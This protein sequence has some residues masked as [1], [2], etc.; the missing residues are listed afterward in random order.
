[1]KDQNQT[2]TPPGMGMS[3]EAPIAD[4]A[5]GKTFDHIKEEFVEEV[6]QIKEKWSL[7]LDLRDRR[8]KDLEGK[9]AQ[10]KQEE[11]ES[12]L[13]VVDDADST[14]QILNRYLQGQQ[15]AVLHVVGDQARDHIDSRNYAVILIEATGV[16]EPNVDGL[17]LS[18][19]LCEAGKGNNVVVMSSRPGD[20]IK[21]RVEQA[22]ATFLR[23]PLRREQ[24]VQLVRKNLLRH[25][26]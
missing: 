11:P 19:Q 25:R 1:M 17:A 21:H 6:E 13:L 7:L 24:V 15:V 2:E 14:A 12:P 9:M 22:G 10:G 18:Q 20:A 5:A 8:I 4:G 3:E 16:V 26:N 23:K